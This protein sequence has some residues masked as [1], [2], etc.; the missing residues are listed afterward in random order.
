MDRQRVDLVLKLALAV[1]GQGDDRNRRELG[2]IHLLKYVYLADLAWA[3]RHGGQT[4]TGAPWSFHRFGPWAAGVHERIEPVV[5]DVEATERIIQSK[6]GD[7]F[8]RWRLLDAA[9]LSKLDELLPLG[10]TSSVKAAVHRFGDDTPGLLN[11]VYSTKPMLLAAPGERLDFSVAFIA[12]EPREPT[13][14]QEPAKQGAKAKKKENRRLEEAR[15]LVADALM[16]DRA[17][18][19]S[20][21]VP[22]DPAP[23]YDSIFAEGV[24]WLDALDGEPLKPQ[25]GRL[26]FSPTIWKSRARDDRDDE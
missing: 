26:T 6:E 7:D 15:R 13:W 23:R 9:L 3:E 24:E 8:K 17:R 21:R 1:A 4:Y 12:T 18:E 14:R 2:P 16:R 11:F 20:T 25:K 22:P 10:I 5:A 19:Q